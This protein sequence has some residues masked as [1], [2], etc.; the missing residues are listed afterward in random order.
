MYFLAAWVRNRWRDWLSSSVPVTLLIN[1]SAAVLC[2]ERCGLPWL[3]KD[4]TYKMRQLKVTNKL[5]S[6]R[7]QGHRCQTQ[8]NI[9][10]SCKLVYVDGIN[11]EKGER[12]VWSNRYIMI[13]ST[14][15]WKT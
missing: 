4:K 5:N 2:A 1:S 14:R 7:V 8:Q 13:E 15:A 12:K 10:F 6:K 3:K 11:I 9:F